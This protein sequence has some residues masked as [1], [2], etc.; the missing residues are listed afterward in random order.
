MRRLFFLFSALVPLAILLTSHF[1]SPHALWA[2]IPVSPLLALGF[3]DVFQKKHAI[4]RNFPL[5]G[6]VRYLAEK[7]RPEIQQYFIEQAEEGRPFSRN[8]RSVV[9]QRAKKQLATRPFGTQ[10]DVYEQGYEFVN[11]SLQPLHCD[12]RELRVLVGGRDCKKPYSASILNISAMSYGSLS[13]NAIR[14]LN[15]GAHLGAFAHNTGEGGLSPHHEAGGGDIIWEIG[16]GYFGCRDE[17]GRFSAEAFREKATRDQ[18]KMIEIKLSQ[19]AKP[20]HGGILP[21]KKVTSEIAAIR[22]I[23][24]GKDCVSPP[25]HSAFS[26]PLEMVRWIQ[27]LR[28]LSGGK[29]IG[30]KLCVGKRREF[31]ALMKAVHETGIAPDY[32]VVDGGEGGTGAAPMEFSD[33]VGTPL[34]EGLVFVHNSLV[35]INRRKDVK[36]FVAGRITTGFDMIA[37]MSMGA[38]VCYSARGMMLALGCIQA[39]QCN[40]NTCPTGVATNDPHLMVGLDI[41]DKRVRVKNFH[42]QTVESVAELLGAMGLK[43]S[44]ELRPWHLMHRIGAFEIKHYGELFDYIA[45]GALLGKDLPPAFAR[46]WKMASS[47]SW[48]AI[49][50]R[51]TQGSFGYRAAA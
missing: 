32:I 4:R 22:G 42:E 44:Q 19:G 31:L 9:Y 29:P 8:I 45:P 33:H 11:H 25:G 12:P 5:L 40:Q 50:D 48:L 15:G 34:N 23:P 17:Q 21:A 36:V 41:T 18:V 39:L 30:I 2:L 46:A 24:M 16:T 37:K 47:D 20:G 35:G 26:S 1:V 14:A 49:D 3:Y 51:A 43:H 27:Q 10:L 28:D 38:D 7:V 13:S 6:H